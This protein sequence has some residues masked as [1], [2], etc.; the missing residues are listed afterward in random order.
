MMLETLWQEGRHASR[1][2]YRAP[3]FTAASVITLTLGIGATTAIF[4]VVDAAILKPLPYPDAD[5]LVVLAQPAGGAQTGQI[6]L[7]VRESAR[8]FDGIAAQ[9]TANGWN[10][11]ARDI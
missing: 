6:F 2:L 8:L 4:A 3:G 7:R 5:R 1:S 10:L 9:G 11:A